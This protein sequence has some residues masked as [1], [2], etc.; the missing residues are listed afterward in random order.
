MRLLLR[1]LLLGAVSAA[2]FLMVYSVVSPNPD[3]ASPASWRVDRA[4][5]E[6][7]RNRA[8]DRG[9]ISGSPGTEAPA[10][11]RADL[12]ADAPLA[13]VNTDIARAVQAAGGR[14]VEAVEQG[15]DPEAPERVELTVSA[16]GEITHEVTLSRERDRED[17]DSPR[18]AVVFDDLGYTTEGLAGELLALP[19]PI[20]FAVLPGLAHSRDF[21]KAATERGHELLLHVPMEP[22]DTV[23]HRPGPNALFVELDPEENLRRL[24]SH[25]DGLGGY[26]GVSNHMGS[27]FTA[28]PDLMEPVLEEIRRRGE[29]LFFLDS[30]TTGFS[31]VREAARQAG[32]P[33]VSNNLFLDGGDEGPRLA[34]VRTDRVADIARQQ[35]YAV[36][37]GHV[38]PETVAAVREAIVAWRGEGIRLVP[39]SDLLH[40]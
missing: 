11:L 28:R 24:R 19:A 32:V 25:L 37:I 26:V 16:D 21:A 30:R 22:L 13:Q 15:R 40:R 33:Y 9:A 18:I 6:V 10:E 29:D 12:P 2:V 5:D 35:G 20:T 14:V 1:G 36:A 8:V 17:A 23:R 7:L 3:G 27:R 39:L 4:L 34:R 31:A 38:H